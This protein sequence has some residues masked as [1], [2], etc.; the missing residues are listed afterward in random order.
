ME[1][2]ARMYDILAILVN[3]NSKNI[4]NIIQKLL[5]DL[6]KL[7]NFFSLR[8]VLVD[9]NSI[10]NSFNE[11]R[12][13]IIEHI[14]FDVTLLKLSRNYG[15][16]RA[17]NIA[18][19]FATKRWRFK[20]LAILNDDLFIV[21]E[22]VI[23]ILKYLEYDDI[24]GV[25]GTIMQML[26]P[27]LI[28]NAGFLIDQHGLTY[29]VCRGRTIDCA[30]LYMPSYLSGACSFYKVDV[31]DRT[32][33]KPFD[34]AIESYYDDKYLGLMLWSKG[35]KLLHVPLITAYHIGTFSYSD[36]ISNKIVKGMRWFKGIMLADIIPAK[37][38]RGAASKII[39]LYYIMA[40]VF[41]S[42]ITKCNYIKTYIEALNLLNQYVKH[43]KKRLELY[44]IPHIHSI[45]IIRSPSKGIKLKQ[46]YIP[47]RKQHL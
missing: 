11:I 1:M 43:R 20:Y 30:R 3:Y 26:F 28:D 40:A 39:L 10:D 45:S 12:S 38:I 23:K 34:E 9:N 18:Y 41:A 22:N 5:M 16:P 42:F 33:G 17:V 15:F 44:K 35:Y 8:L 36:V 37:E 6:D 19:R 24:A 32:L 27:H 31:I 47:R 21:P 7:N 25:Q 14:D 2:H 29:P 13:F 4:I 46:L